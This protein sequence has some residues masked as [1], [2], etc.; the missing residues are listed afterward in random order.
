MKLCPWSAST[1]AIAESY[2]DGY[3]LNDS[4][5][6][7]SRL[8][9]C[10]SCIPILLPTHAL[11]YFVPRETRGD[12]GTNRFDVIHDLKPRNKDTASKRR[13]WELVAAA[14]PKIVDR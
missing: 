4:C 12:E 11:L 3:D 13:G 7:L 6:L 5:C 9:L 10:L 14:Q 1:K 8:S 2:P